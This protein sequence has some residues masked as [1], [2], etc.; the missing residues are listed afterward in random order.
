MIPRIL[1]NTIKKGQKKGYI[2]LI[3]GPRRVGKTVLLQQLVQPLKK[4]QII[5]FDGDTQEARD[6]LSTTSQ[7]SLSKLV[8]GKNY[9][10]IDEAQRIP[11]IGLSLKILIDQFPDKT[12]YVTGS[13]SLMLSRGLQEPL[14]GRTNKYRLFPLSTKEMSGK[15]QKHQISS[16]LEN[17]L[18]DYHLPGVLD[19]IQKIGFKSVNWL[20]S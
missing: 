13:S 14:T 10:V 16:L 3:Y 11:N 20:Q 18:L 19:S 12:F 7:V 8:N 5:W 6:S 15:L 1:I 2:N 4:E 9:I 17:Q